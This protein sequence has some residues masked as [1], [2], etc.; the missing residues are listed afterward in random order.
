MLLTVN[1]ES[2]IEDIMAALNSSR[3]KDHVT[4]QQNLNMSNI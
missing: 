1:D 3:K 2:S 4:F